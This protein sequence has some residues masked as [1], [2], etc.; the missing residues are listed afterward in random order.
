MVSVGRVSSPAIQTAGA[1]RVA[2][3]S[4]F[5][6]S[7]PGTSGATGPAATSATSMDGMLM[8]QQ[9][10]EDGAT[11]DRQARKHGKAMLE[12]LAAL[13]RELLDG[14]VDPGTLERLGALT[15]HC[16]EAADP[17]LR[18]TLGAVSLRVQVEIARRAM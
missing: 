12:G 11:R 16:P 9:Q 4:G 18:A 3:G 5:A 8:L 7:T 1:R 17:G 2:G 15:E 14:D 6:V 13:Q 10:V